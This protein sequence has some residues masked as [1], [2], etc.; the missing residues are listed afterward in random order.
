[1]DAGPVLQE[2][3]SNTCREILFPLKCSPMHGLADVENDLQNGVAYQ[4]E[5]SSRFDIVYSKRNS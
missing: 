1:M 3:V 2:N 4:H 5:G